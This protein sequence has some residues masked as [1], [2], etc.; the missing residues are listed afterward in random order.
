MCVFV[1][2][3]RLQIYNNIWR[4]EKDLLGFVLSLN[5][6]K[7]ITELRIGRRYIYTLHQV[8]NLSFPPFLLLKRG[9]KRTKEIEIKNCSATF[10]TVFKIV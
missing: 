6:V 2:G 10:V 3:M 9:G 4:S 8:T 1:C 7:F 5:H